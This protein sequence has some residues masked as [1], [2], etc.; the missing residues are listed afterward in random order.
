MRTAAAKNEIAKHPYKRGMQCWPSLERFSHTIQLSRGGIKLF[1]YDAGRPSM[2]AILLIHG[3]GDEADTWRYLVGPLSGYYR[4]IAP[5]LPGFGRSGPAAPSDPSAPR[6]YSLEYYART[7]LELLESLGI[8]RFSLVGHSLGGMVAHQIALAVPSRVER[9]VLIDGSLVVRSQKMSIQSLLFLIPGI[10][11]WA[12]NR[13]RKDPDAA[14]CSL[15]PYYSSLERLPEADRR[16]LYQR[17]NERVW[18]EKQRK[19]FLSTLRSMA[20]NLPGLRKG[21]HERLAKLHV[22]TLAVWGDEDQ[23]SGLENVRALVE[24]QPDVRLLILRGAGH[25]VHQERPGEV[26]NAILGMDV[27]EEEVKSKK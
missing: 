26:A 3:L 21:L 8:S 14:Y 11:E 4:V 15:E 10:G 1:Y 12:Y 20:A 5:D 27:G 9:L 13:L 24:M 25:N 7:A 22:P 19:A 2:P 23:I 6:P 18:S 16:F 17:V